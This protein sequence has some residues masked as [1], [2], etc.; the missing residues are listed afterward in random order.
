MILVCLQGD[1]CLCRAC[2]RIS[3]VEFR[4]GIARG[5]G[6]FVPQRTC[7]AAFL[8][9]CLSPAAVELR[10]CCKAAARDGCFTVRHRC[11]AV[12]VQCLCIGCAARN[13][14]VAAIGYAVVAARDGNLAVRDLRHAPRRAA[15]GVLLGHGETANNAP[16]RL[17][18]STVELECAVLDGD[19]RA[20]DLC[21]AAMLQPCVCADGSADRERT[22]RECGEDFR[23]K[24]PLGGG[25]FSV[26][27]DVS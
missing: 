15:A 11:R 22:R 9:F 13:G 16:L 4:D 3:A 18:C 12:D 10:L 5:E 19:L 6:E 25:L 8:R 26:N 14:D 27:P 1:G 24:Y 20:G 17:R 7:L 21:C 2:I 23:D